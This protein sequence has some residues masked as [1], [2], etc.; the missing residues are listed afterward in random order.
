[1]LPWTDLAT[2]VSPLPCGTAPSGSF[3]LRSTLSHPTNSLSRETTEMQNSQ[4]QAQEQDTA[5]TLVPIK[6]ECW[7]SRDSGYLFLFSIMYRGYRRQRLHL[8]SIADEPSNHGR[9]K[10]AETQRDA[11]QPGTRAMARW[12][13]WAS[14]GHDGVGV[15][16][17]P[18][19]LDPPWRTK[20]C[21]LSACHAAHH[22]ATVYSSGR[23]GSIQRLGAN[24]LH[25]G[26]SL[27]RQLI[28]TVAV[29]TPT[30]RKTMAALRRVSATAGP[31]SHPTGSQ[32]TRPHKIPG[33]IGWGSLRLTTCAEQSVQCTRTVARCCATR[34]RGPRST[35]A[36]FLGRKN[37]ALSPCPCLPAN[38]TARHHQC[39]RMA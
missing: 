11:A 6:R 36:L 4:L 8:L 38:S 21:R 15:S 22:P 5:W 29:T 13:C 9:S 37:A 14:T 27:G 24:T 23:D 26:L 18:F 10:R 25:T 7:G 19:L 34:G 30:P 32:A 20:T 33:I 39:R 12:R 35:R 16:P 31:P 17:A 3:T 1:M 2:F 28:H